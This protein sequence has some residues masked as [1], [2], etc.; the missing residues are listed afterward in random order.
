ME[1]S[2]A[3]LSFDDIV[4]W[5]GS[6]KGAGRKI[7]GRPCVLHRERAV[8]KYWNPIHVTLRAIDGLPSFRIPALYAAFE[9]AVRTTR[10]DD[11]HIIEFSVQDNHLHLI[12]EADDETALSRGMKSFSVRANRLFN[13]AAGR[14][15]GPVWAGRYHTTELTTPLAVRNALVYVLQN[16]K[17]HQR[18]APGAARIDPCSSARWF[19]GWT[20]TRKS[21]DGERPTEDA[22]SVLLRTG[23]KKHGLIDPGETPKHAR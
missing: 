17:K 18:V 5:G 2:P 4:H 3:Q 23:W 15:R 7:V 1:N 8:H 10:R 13:A 6:R 20:R 12:V 21:A 14:G 22:R 16:Y 11:F 9:K 19:T